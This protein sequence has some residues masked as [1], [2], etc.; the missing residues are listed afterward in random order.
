MTRMR[1]TREAQMS[2]KAIRKGLSAS[3]LS[4]Q[5]TAASEEPIS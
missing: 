2:M 4:A 1:P 5:I 3:G